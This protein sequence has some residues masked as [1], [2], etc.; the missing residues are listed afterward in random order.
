MVKLRTLTDYFFENFL[1][2]FLG[3]FWKLFLRKLQWKT[4]KILTRNKNFKEKNLDKFSETPYKKYMLFTLYSEISN[5]TIFIRT[6]KSQRRT[7]AQRADLCK[8]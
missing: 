8:F 5:Q 3:E 7:A 1:E 6:I 4:R 2:T